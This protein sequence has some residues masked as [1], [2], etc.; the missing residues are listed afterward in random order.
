[1]LGILWPTL[2]SGGI[3]AACL[4]IWATQPTLQRSGPLRVVLIVATIAT[5]ALGLIAGVEIVARVM[6]FGLN[7]AF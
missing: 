5:V 3:A 1:M 6:A 2:V 7:D 4:A